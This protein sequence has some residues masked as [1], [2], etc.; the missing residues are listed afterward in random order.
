MIR[1]GPRPA[2]RFAMIANAA[3]EDD[4]LTWRARGVLA[5]LL[6]RPEGWSTSAERLAGQSPK[7]KEGRDAMR[8]VL[9][10]LEAAGY[11]LREK[12]QDARGRWSTGMVVYDS[13][14]M[15]GTLTIPEG[16]T[17][18]QLVA[19][20]DGMVE[21]AAKTGS[22]P[23]A[24]AASMNTPEPPNVEATGGVL[25]T[26]DSLGYAMDD[27]SADEMAAEAA[28]IMA[29]PLVLDDSKNGGS[30]GVGKPAVGQ[31]AVGQPAVG[32]PGPIS[33]KETKTDNKKDS[34]S[35]T[36]TTETPI[37]K[38]MRWP[39]REF[40]SEAGSRWSWL[41]ADNA[42]VLTERYF[43]FVKSKGWKYSPEGWLKFIE[44]EDLARTKRAKTRAYTPN[45]VPL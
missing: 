38:L 29:Q 43:E 34:S 44:D 35:P 25:Y 28:K 1:R 5:Y 6:S 33:K 4:R 20:T 41:N 11:L 36:T 12:V 45:G 23:L 15:L 26:P 27:G 32:K 8:A 3:L 2:D 17:V 9:A 31:P 21:I 40:L 42:A 19:G 39:G 14:M 24:L 16:V 37:Q 13:P 22:E 7:G 30:P 10:E 18:S